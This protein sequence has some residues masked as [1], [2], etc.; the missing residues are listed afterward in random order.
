MIKKILETEIDQ[1]IGSQL[2]WL[3]ATVVITLIV[4][5]F[6]EQIFRWIKT[7]F[8]KVKKF[9]HSPYREQ[10]RIYKKIEKYE[11]SIYFK[12]EKPNEL[13]KDLPH[14]L[15]PRISKVFKTNSKKHKIVYKALKD[16]V[17][18][19]IESYP[20]RLERFYELYPYEREKDEIRDRIVQKQI[21]TMTSNF[22][23]TLNNLKRF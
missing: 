2:S 22:E 6:T 18:Y 15:D 16:K 5:L 13:P 7:V 9:Y 10:K 23:N 17:N 1:T 12:L 11:R 14:I 8:F 3:V 21:E 4:S 19:Y 20:E